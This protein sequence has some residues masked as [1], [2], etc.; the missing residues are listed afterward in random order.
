[1]HLITVLM[2]DT[3]VV[4]MSWCVLMRTEKNQSSPLLFAVICS[5]IFAFSLFLLNVIGTVPYY[6]DGTPPTVSEKHFQDEDKTD[7]TSVDD[8]LTPTDFTPIKKEVVGY[9]PE[10]IIIPA[11]NKE[12][13]ITSPLSRDVALLDKELLTSVVRFPGSGVLGKD[14][15]V[16]IFG[17]SSGYRTVKNEYFKAFN[18][19][20]KLE[21]GSVIQLV[22]KGVVHVYQVTSVT[23]VESSDALV[24]LRV[25]KGERKLTLSTCD[26]FGKKSER[27]VV[28]AEFLTEYS[29][30]DEDF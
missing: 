15:N 19:I 1:M 10:K 16:F 26:S 30:A 8:G 29:E 25:T 3:R 9:L 21:K 5:W 4:E 24:D 13:P 14:G 23:H 7:I 17:H 6:V 12:L 20:Q 28:E 11:L 22:G 27:F 2:L 18:G